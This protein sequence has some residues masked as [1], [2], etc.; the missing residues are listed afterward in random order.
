M[1]HIV[2]CHVPKPASISFLVQMSFVMKS[3]SIFPFII[4][5]NHHSNIHYCVVP[6]IECFCLF[7]RPIAR[8]R[9]YFLEGYTANLMNM[10][11]GQTISISSMIMEVRLDMLRLSDVVLM[12]YVIHLIYHYLNFFRYIF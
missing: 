6:R 9:W 3:L 11:H 5:P 12:S 7:F 10:S 8:H 4:Q 1:H 2:H